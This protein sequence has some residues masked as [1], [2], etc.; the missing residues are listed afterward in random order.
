MNEREKNDQN[1]FVNLL[2]QPLKLYVSSVRKCKRRAEVIVNAHLCRHLPC[3][4]F[5]AT[6]NKLKSKDKKKLSNKLQPRTNKNVLKLRMRKTKMKSKP[7][8]CQNVQTQNMRS[9]LTHTLTH[10]HITF[11]GA[12]KTNFVLSTVSCALNIKNKHTAAIRTETLV[13]FSYSVIAIAASI[14]LTLHECCS[15]FFMA[16]RATSSH[17]RD[18]FMCTV[19]LSPS[20]AIQ[21]KKIFNVPYRFHRFFLTPKQQKIP[22]I[23][24]VYSHFVRKPQKIP[25]EMGYDDDTQ[26]QKKI[27]KKNRS[28]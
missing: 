11:I 7:K 13:F 16:L 27:Q 25:Y 23:F 20:A 14:Q 8:W 22:H 1:R 4:A 15:I 9:L 6:K 26:Q 3:N 12:T 17:R 21:M 18:H 10:E 5:K 2:F 24:H 28:V 19:Q